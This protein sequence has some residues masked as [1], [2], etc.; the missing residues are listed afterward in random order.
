M[1]DVVRLVVIAVILAGVVFGGSLGGVS[2]AAA[3]FV[4]GVVLLVVPWRGQPLRVWVWLF[5]RR[6]RPLTLR[7][8]ATVASDRSG[9]VRFQ[10]GVAV[11][12][13]QLLG[14]RHQ[15]TVFSGST[16][17]R[18]ANAVDAVAL[19][20]LIRRSIG[21]RWESFSIICAGV[22]RRNS[23]DYP[24]VYDT[25]IGTNPYAGR[26]ETWM[27][28]RTRALSNG[29]EMHWRPTLGTAVVAAT[30][31]IAVALRCSGIRARVATA[32]DLVE[33]ERRLG[34]DVL[35]PR[36]RHWHSLR[37]QSGWHTTYAYRAADI[38]SEA[39]A[40]PWSL[41]ADGIIQNLTVFSDGSASATV[42][43]RTAQPPTA[44][45]G[46]MLRT[47]PGEQH[48]AAA[49]NLAG[50]RLEI[51]GL[52]RGP[53]PAA[54]ILPVGASGVLLGKLAGGDRLLLPLGD[55]AEPVRVSI[56]ADDTVA[57]RIIIRAAAAGERV[58]VHTTDV[59][60][61]ASVRMP[62]VAVIEHPRPVAGTTV[63]VMDGT[64]ASAPRAATVIS[65]RPAGS[66]PEPAADI[67]IVQ[68]GPA[69]L[70]VFAGGEW[71]DVEMELFRAENRY[72]PE[73]LV[74]KALFATTDSG[75]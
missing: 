18:T 65:V 23:G 10:D 68:S 22:R 56:A 61:W 13:I 2:G 48:H 58:T 33:L 75:D 74:D 70:E 25:L 62:S 57:K 31:R 63:S 8:P 38:T 64:V 4:L 24:Q 37:E 6:N 66:A 73:E 46:M 34:A 20:S 53:L 49:A 15:P 44:S 42:S 17:A 26:R 21:L 29:D 27:V 5:L 3:G 51:R 40:Q 16:S 9:A 71:N 50:P 12:A 32:A 60:R 67:V 43:V 36:N 28:L 14:K 19:A 45:P 69:H 54:L 39:L 41:R 11:A 1:R 7:E 52:Q 47:L 72:A 55:P 35:E 30:Q 59:G